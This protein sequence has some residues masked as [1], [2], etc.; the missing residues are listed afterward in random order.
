MASVIVISDTGPIHYLTLLGRVELL[1]H[2][3]G[4]VLV[5][6]AVLCELNH[7]STPQP[8]RELIANLPPWLK[9]VACP[10][11]DPRF[12][13]LGIGEREALTVA[14]LHPGSV[15]LCD[16]QAARSA[17]M[18][19]HIMVCGTL[20]VLRDA[21]LSN[22]LDIRQEVEKLRTQTN[23]RGSERLFESLCDETERL[24]RERA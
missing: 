2:F 8:I 3:Y 5:P 1:A 9:E 20:G 7:S 15:L 22:L 12:D 19:E 24:I 17:A 23:F 13:G 18:S 21:A 10:T 4:E 14:L 6:S 16:D 11:T